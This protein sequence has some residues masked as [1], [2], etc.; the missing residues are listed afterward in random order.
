MQ[1][2]TGAAASRVMLGAIMWSQGRRRA[3]AREAEKV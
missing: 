1:P 2:T 3:N